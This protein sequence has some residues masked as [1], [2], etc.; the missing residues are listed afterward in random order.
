MGSMLR[1]I[2][3]FQHVR[4]M[5][6]THSLGRCVGEQSSEAEFTGC[7]SHFSEQ[8]AGKE[9]SVLGQFLCSSLVSTCRTDQ[10][11]LNGALLGISQLKHRVDLMNFNRPSQF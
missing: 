10:G 9:R 6:V 4:D 3:E 1:L 5:F 8:N 2:T 7:E 11:A